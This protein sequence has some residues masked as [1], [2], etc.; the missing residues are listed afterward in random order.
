MARMDQD[1]QRLVIGMDPRKRSSRSK[2]YD[3]ALDGAR[4]AANAGGYAGAACDPV[5]SLSW[6]GAS[7]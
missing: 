7:R 1:R 3:L 4:L 5:R 6:Q 2:R